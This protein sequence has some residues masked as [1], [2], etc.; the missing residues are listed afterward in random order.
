MTRN[1]LLAIASGMMTSACAILPFGGGNADEGAIVLTQVP[2]EPLAVCIGQA[3]GTMPE[4]IPGGFSVLTTGAQPLRLV[5]SRDNVQTSVR[6][7]EGAVVPSEVS[8]EV[9]ACGLK[10][11]PPI[12]QR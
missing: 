4:S 6:A 5:V 1:L 9:I 3:F 2:A 8:R 10:L 12:S 7:P 11:A